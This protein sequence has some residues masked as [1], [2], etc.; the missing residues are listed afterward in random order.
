MNSNDEVEKVL[1]IFKK[2]KEEGRSDHEWSEY[3]SLELCLELEQKIDRNW[4]WF[5]KKECLEW[6]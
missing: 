1:K 6:R 5:P 3:L 4:H 2:F